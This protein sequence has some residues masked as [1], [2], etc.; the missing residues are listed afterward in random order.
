MTRVVKVPCANPVCG[1]HIMMGA[2]WA[3]DDARALCR[4]CVTAGRRLKDLPG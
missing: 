4:D 2:S 3:G 1:N